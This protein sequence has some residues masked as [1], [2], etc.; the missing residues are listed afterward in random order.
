VVD[1]ASDETAGL[2]NAQTAWFAV[3]VIAL[4][5]LGLIG[6]LMPPKIKKIE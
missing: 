2:L 4:G 6:F 5:V 1:D 3:I